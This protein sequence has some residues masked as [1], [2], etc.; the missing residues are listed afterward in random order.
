MSSYQHIYSFYMY[1]TTFVDKYITWNM[2]CAD[3]LDAVDKMMFTVNE[4]K[5]IYYLNLYI[6]KVIIITNYLFL[7]FNNNHEAK[8]L[9]VKDPLNFWNDF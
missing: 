4:K 3:I 6:S 7:Y 8:L 9:N 1:S 2:L 5:H